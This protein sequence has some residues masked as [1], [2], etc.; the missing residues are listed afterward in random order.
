MKSF[1]L[2]GN[3]DFHY[4]DNAE[5]S[6]TRYIICAGIGAKTGAS[7]G[8]QTLP[9]AASSWATLLHSRGTWLTLQEMKF[10]RSK[11]E[12]VSHDVVSIVPPFTMRMQLLPECIHQMQMLYEFIH[13]MKASIY[14]LVILAKKKKTKAY[15][16]S[17]KVA[18]LFYKWGYVPKLLLSNFC[19]LA[20][21]KQHSES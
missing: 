19:A 15:H 8:S 7:V 5:S 1:F 3:Q 18:M 20:F 17:F 13:Q 9:I 11:C 10:R 14:V 21:H 16:F 2:R 4:Y 12:K 6:T